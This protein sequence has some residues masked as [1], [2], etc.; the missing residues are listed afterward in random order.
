[1]NYKE[2]IK[3]IAFDFD[4]TLIDFNYQTTDYTKKALAE[5]AK[6]EYKVCL[7]SGRPCFLA[8][9]AFENSFGE[10]PLDYVF[11]CN[12]WSLWISKLEKLNFYFQ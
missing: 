10:Y 12:G 1:M 7:S 11:G 9:K 8:V 2:E 4:G 6:S 3:A 5:L